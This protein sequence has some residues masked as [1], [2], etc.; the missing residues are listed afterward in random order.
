VPQEG[1][2][3]T[4][5]PSGSDSSDSDSRPE[6]KGGANNRATGTDDK[7]PGRTHPVNAV[8]FPVTTYLDYVDP[9]AS[10]NLNRFL[11]LVK[12]LLAIPHFIVPVFLWIAAFVLIVAW[13]AILFT[14]RYSRGMFNFVEGVIRWGQRSSRT[15]C[16][17]SPT[18]TRPFRLGP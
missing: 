14:G 4:R 15:R 6:P 5:T 8:W 17:S 18:G 12:W 7:Q 16:C 13:F 10:R 2:R 1:E 3:G 11:P 9:D